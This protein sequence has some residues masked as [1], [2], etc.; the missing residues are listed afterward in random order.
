MNFDRLEIEIRGYKGDRVVSYDKLW[1]LEELQQFHVHYFSQRV[2]EQI[3]SMV[4]EM[5]NETR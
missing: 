5:S 2:T 1:T 3:Q 4:L